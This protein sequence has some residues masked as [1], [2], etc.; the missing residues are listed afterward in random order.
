MFDNKYILLGLL[1]LFVFLTRMGYNLHGIGV[2]F[3]QNNFLLSIKSMQIGI[4]SP[5]ITQQV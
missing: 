2:P 3:Q 5:K 4:V 1:D